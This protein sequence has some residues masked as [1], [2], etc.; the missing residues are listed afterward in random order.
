MLSQLLFV[1]FYLD[2]ESK[3]THA[4]SQMLITFYIVLQSLK[5]AS[6]QHN[7]YV[8]TF[9]ILTSY[10][11]YYKALTIFTQNGEDQMFIDHGIIPLFKDCS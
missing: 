1:K 4:K 7:Q 10:K 3:H 6:K 5:Q 8:M 9:K 2:Y 11:Y